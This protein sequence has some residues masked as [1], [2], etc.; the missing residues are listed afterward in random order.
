[1]D[2]ETTR[3][4][5][6]ITL[7]ATMLHATIDNDMSH[8]TYLHVYDA[9]HDMTS[10]K[11]HNTVQVRTQDT[12]HEAQYAIRDTTACTYIYTDET[13][14]VAEFIITHRVEVRAA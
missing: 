2:T 10:D 1:M 5:D 14:E 13:Q 12:G 8:T 4:Q 3:V 7:Q 11:Q 9:R 6:N